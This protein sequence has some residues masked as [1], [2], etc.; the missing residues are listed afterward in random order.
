MSTHTRTAA[1][2]G[3][4]LTEAFHAIYDVKDKLPDGNSRYTAYEAIQKLSTLM[5]ALGWDVPN[6]HDGEGRNAGGEA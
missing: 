5:D 2:A 1:E 6:R 3:A 4:G